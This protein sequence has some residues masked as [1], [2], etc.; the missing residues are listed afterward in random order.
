M[1]SHK[2]PSPFFWGCSTSAHQIEGDVVNDWSEWE[3]SDARLHSLATNGQQP[4]E[5]ISGAACES[6]NRFEED[7]ACL[8]QLGVNSYRFS[9]EWSRIE[10]VKGQFDYDAIQ[11]YKRFIERLREEQIEPFV[12]LWHWP[13]PL[14]VRDQGGWLSKQTVEDFSSFTQVVTTELSDLVTYW[15]TINEPQVYASQS[16]YSALWPPQEKSLLKALRVI[17]HLVEAHKA[18]YYVIKSHNA[19]AQV[20]LASHNIHFSAKQ[21]WGVNQ[22]LA[23]TMSMLWNDWFLDQVNATQDFIGL[24]YYFHKSV[25]IH[26]GK[27]DQLVSDLGWELYPEGLEHV[28]NDLKRFHKP[29]YITEHGLADK[30]DRHREW[31]L[32][33]SLKHIHASIG[34]GVDV[35]GYFHWSLLDN[36]EWA[37][38][39]FPR[40]GLFEV[41]R[42]T[43]KRT[44]RPSV[45]VYKSIIEQNQV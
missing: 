41:D 13:V 33:E 1:S 8:K 45:S 7:I 10:P 14:W 11:R 25:D 27:K 40:F 16:Y 12:T 19:H 37:D 28:L 15:I 38:G 24:N 9:L 26:L 35:R 4:E 6:W 34:A 23:K 36:F 20:G 30:D 17:K 21:P 29:V 2:F 42:Q 43:C 3:R 5:F 22:L 18:A 32:K 39:F 31:Y 44:A